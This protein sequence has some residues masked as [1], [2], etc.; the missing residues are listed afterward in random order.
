MPRVTSRR[1]ETPELQGEGSFVLFRKL[2]WK[3]SKEARRF[4]MIGDVRARTDLT[5]EEI[6]KM[7]AE[8]EKLTIELVSTGVLQWNWQDEDG[9]PLPLPK[10]TADLDILNADEVAFLVKC[11][12]GSYPDAETEAKN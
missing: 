7:L 8:E 2:S 5:V 6:D 1:I 9:K 11:S 3:A 12:A 4:M 10:K